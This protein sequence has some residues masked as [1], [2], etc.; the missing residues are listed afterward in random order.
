MADRMHRAIEKCTPENQAAI[1]GGTFRQLTPRQCCDFQ[2]YH[3]G[4]S[5]RMSWATRFVEEKKYGPLVS[6]S[7]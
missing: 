2:N 6:T 5:S 1:D 3:G 4:N 7:F